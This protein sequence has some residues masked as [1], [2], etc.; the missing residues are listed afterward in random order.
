MSY[1]RLKSALDLYNMVVETRPDLADKA[2][3]LKEH[4][5]VGNPQKPT[6]YYHLYGT[7]RLLMGDDYSKASGA[8]GEAMRMH[9]LSSEKNLLDAINEGPA[10]LKDDE[11]FLHV[12]GIMRGRTKYFLSSRSIKVGSL[13]D[14]AWHAMDLAYR[15]IIASAIESALRRETIGAKS[16]QYVAAYLMPDKLK[17]QEL[18]ALSVKYNREHMDLLQEALAFI[19]S[20]AKEYSIQIPEFMIIA[21]TAA[22][23]ANK[24]KT[25]PSAGADFT[26]SADIPKPVPLSAAK[27]AR[28]ESEPD[29]GNHFEK[30]RAAA[31][32]KQSAPSKGGQAVETEEDRNMRILKRDI[33]TLLR[34]G[35]ISERAMTVYMWLKGMNKNG[36]PRTLTDAVELLK[37]NGGGNAD[38]IDKTYV[39]LMVAN[40]NVRLRALNSDGHENRALSPQ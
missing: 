20:T 4:Y 26:G 9:V 14:R 30:N 15:P 12:R 11:E 19:G 25:T 7:L 6:P 40:V 28:G 32:A 18:K 31:A 8:M 2:G 10:F 37:K 22:S 1:G 33:Q 35:D 38:K 34:A 13:Y 3:Q 27:P 23:L 29:I 16:M 21:V 24:E 36:D 5:L 39:R 17:A